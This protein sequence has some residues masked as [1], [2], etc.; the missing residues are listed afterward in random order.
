MFFFA[1]LFFFLV[2]FWMGAER[3]EVGGYISFLVFQKKL[4]KPSVSLEK[5]RVSHVTGFFSYYV[6]MFFFPSLG[7]AGLQIVF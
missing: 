7:H 4:R 5:V 6:L 1:F 2:Y 3:E